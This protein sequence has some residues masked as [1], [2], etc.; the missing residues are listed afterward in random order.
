M[1]NT[2]KGSLLFR[3]AP[4]LALLLML[5]PILAGLLG[6]LLPA[7]GWMP[8]L[9]Q[10]RLTLAPFSDLFVTPG[11]LRSLAL[12]LASGLIATCLAVL[13]T[14]GLLAGWSDTRLLRSMQQLISPLLSIPHAATALGF[15]FLF[16]PSG[17]LVRMISPD[18][19]GWSRPPDWLFPHDPFGLAMIIGLTI[20]EM[21]FLLLVSLAA[22]PQIEAGKMA[23]A[24]RTLG[25]GKVASWL[26][27]VWPRL[28]RQIRLPVFATIAYASS[29]VDV[30]LI[31]GP[32]NPPTLAVQLVR[33]MSDPDL[34]MRLLASAGALLQLVVTLAA[35]ALWW[36]AERIL[37]HLIAHA[38]GTGRR[39]QKDGVIR[40][41]GALF[42]IA[43]VVIML[44][45]LA[46]LALWSI[47]G[48]WCF[49]DAMPVTL[50]LQNWMRHASMLSEPL[51]N[52]LLIGLLSTLIGLLVTIACL[53]TECRAH[54]TPASRSLSILY[55]PLIVPQ[56]AFLFG[57]QL[58][59][60]SLDVAYSLWSVVLSHLVFVLPYIFLS[61]GAPWRALD[62]RFA[63]IAASLGHGPWSILFRIRLPMLLR[64][65]L[66]A[67]AI[68]FAVSIGQ[69]L[70]TI[71][72]GGG[73][74]ET[75][76]TEA[77]SLSAGGNRRLIG[78]YAMLQML[79]PFLG[80]LL[81]VGVPHIL[82]RNRR[83]MAPTNR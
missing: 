69:Y 40:W 37:S 61:L 33:W 17:W 62:P 9:G 54:R 3:P 60:I 19:T 57:L 70:A 23:T 7:F 30:A 25:Y 52:A 22:L 59:A 35:L 53:E 79:L 41:L 68:G 56:V 67:A 51:L 42:N 15:A 74:W 78:L 58:I 26:Y 66:T 47:A 39:F 5:G 21:P 31:L 50:T 13:L 8:V 55:W 73:R 72:M 65:I 24:A 49:P 12:S 14:I 46:G 45:G 20:K 4:L 44:S 29:V 76:T 82:F 2:E 36:L 16:A 71:L 18:L 38:I 77:V 83:D 34:S 11:L 10:E 81:A 75:I 43:A 28:Y 1:T 27:A 32:T 80:F 63:G 64:P 6:V 48:L